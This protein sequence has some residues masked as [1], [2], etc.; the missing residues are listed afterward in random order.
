[1]GSRFFCAEDGLVSELSLGICGMRVAVLL[2]KGFMRRV[3]GLQKKC[4]VE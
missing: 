3:M 1:M 2:G 4:S